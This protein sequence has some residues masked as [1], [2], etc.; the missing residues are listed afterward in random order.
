MKGAGGTSGGI[1]SFFI[2]V[3]MMCG[4]FYM[5]FNAIRVNSN[6]GM[7]SSIYGFNAW[8]YNVGLTSGMVLIPFIFGVGMLFYNG[9]NIL[10]WVLSMGSL[11]A[12]A[13][14]VISSLH[15]SMRSMSS[16]DL[17]VILVLCAG[18]LGL[19]LKSLRNMESKK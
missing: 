6:F 3:A 7:G 2:G 10:G 16:F 1:G 14:G 12:L 4:G 11:V 5:L 18:G 17:I 8:G 19:F 13:F 9:K 15:F